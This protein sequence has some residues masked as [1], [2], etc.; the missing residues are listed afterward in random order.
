MARKPKNPKMT[1]EEHARLRY[2]L[3]RAAAVTIAADRAG[4]ETLRER[5]NDRLD[6]REVGVVTFRNVGEALYDAGARHAAERLR[7]LLQDVAVIA[8]EPGRNPYL[9]ALIADAVAEADR[10]AGEA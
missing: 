3:E 5:G 8:G 2:E 9:R 7:V 10:L 4:F 1:P 6:F